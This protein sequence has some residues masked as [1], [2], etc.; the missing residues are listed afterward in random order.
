MATVDIHYLRA[1]LHCAERKGLAL[2]PLLAAIGLDA[3]LLG[4]AKARA[5]GEQMT[6]LIQLI[7][8]MLTW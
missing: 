6:R 3:Q 5:H 1:A 2:E 4:Q 8:A 7:W